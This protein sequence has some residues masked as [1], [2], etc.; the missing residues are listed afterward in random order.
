[1]VDVS[2]M[3][4]KMATALRAKAADFI[5]IASALEKLDDLASSFKAKSKRHMS[6]AARKRIATAQRQRWAK[7]H[8]ANG[9]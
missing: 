6:S 2:K 9:K 4:Y 8:K 5:E 3:N 7:W 1:M